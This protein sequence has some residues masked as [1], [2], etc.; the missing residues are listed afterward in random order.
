MKQ[1]PAYKVLIEKIEKLVSSDDPAF[2]CARRV[3][4]YAEVFRDGAKVP[5]KEIPGLIKTLELALAKWRKIFGRF[6]SS[7][8][9]VKDAIKVLKEQLRE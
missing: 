8:E 2:L 3:A 9:K 1:R 5:P 6:P 4:D 7:R